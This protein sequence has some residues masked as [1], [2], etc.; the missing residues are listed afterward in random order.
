VTLFY[1]ENEDGALQAS[2]KVRVPDVV[3]E[4]AG[5][6]QATLNGSGQAVFAGL[7]PGSYPLLVRSETLP[8][9]Y[10]APAALSVEVPGPGE[11][12]VPLSL[13]IGA[14]RP[15]TYLA[16]GDSIT[17]GEGSGDREGFRRR[18]E[19]RLRR[20]FGSASVIAD[21]VSGASSDR[22]VRRINRSL[23]RFHP[24]YALILMGTNDYDDAKDEESQVGSTL[25][26][27]QTIL[28]RVRRNGSIP[29]LATI[30][31]TNV[32]FDAR[33]TPARNRWVSLVDERLASLA[34]T[35]GALLA[36]VHA[37]FLAQG[38]LG[39]LFVDHVHPSDRG[40]EIIAEC[41]FRAITRRAPQA[42]GTAVAP[43]GGKP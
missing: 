1:D 14:N 11:V 30:P 33:A 41:F 27:L 7:R 4:L 6:A 18:L 24:A 35:Q 8:P 42:A 25:L 34:S 12:L 28:E 22:G 19:S 43:G 16:F 37:D 36:D 10:S 2:E 3:L 23:E 29:V 17:D 20:H 5:R 40:Y 26:S 31:P 39:S 15:N 21:G 13:R 9:F 32:G 38:E